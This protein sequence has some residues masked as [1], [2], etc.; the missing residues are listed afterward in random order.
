MGPNA[1]LEPMHA[2]AADTPSRETASSG[3]ETPSTGGAPQDIPRPE[4]EEIPTNLTSR[5]SG[6]RSLLFVLGVKGSPGSSPSSSPGSS[7]G[8]EDPAEGQAGSVASI[9]PRTERP[10]VDRTHAQDEE[11]AA[12][13]SV[14]GASP[15]L[16]TA[17]PEFLP[18]RPIVI[19]VDREGA[20]AGESSTRQDRRAPYD[21]IQILPSRRGQYKKI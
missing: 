12:R 20:P 13:I 2:R 9:G 3:Y 4:P 16:I 15:R 19:N 6:L 14:G 11:D 18:P 17:P 5:L 21:N 1:N 10:A 7:A 8:P